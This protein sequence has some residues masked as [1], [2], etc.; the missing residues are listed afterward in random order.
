MPSLFVRRG[1][2]PG[3]EQ[4]GRGAEELVQGRKRRPGRAWWAEEEFIMP[5]SVINE[6]LSFCPQGTI[7]SGD[8]MALEDYKNDVQRLRG[9]QPGIARRELENMA[10]RQSSF[11]A[12]GLAQ[13]VAKRYAPGVRDDADLDALETA[14]TAAITA[15]IAASNAQTATRLATKRTIG[16]VAFDGSANIHHYATC[17]TAAATAAKTV[18]LSGFALATGARVLVKFTVTNSAA[19]PTLDVNGTGAKPIQYRGAAIAAGTLAANRTYEF[20]Y[21]GAQYELVG[22]VDTNTTYSLATASNDGLMAKGDK[23]KL[24]GI[25]V[26]A[27]VNQNA[28]GNILVGSTT[29]A[30]DT[31]T[32]TLTFVAGTNVTLT[33]DATNDKLTIAA[34]DTTYAAAT[35]SV[36]GLMSAADKKSVDYCEALR[37]SMIGVPRYWRSTTLPANH[38]WAN[39]DL[40]LFSDWP[41]LKKVYDG[42]GFTGMLLAYNAA[43]ATIAA[44]LGK[45]RPNA[46]NPTGL[47][48]PK[49]SDQFFRAWTGGGDGLAGIYN[50]PGLPEIGGH[51]A[52]RVLVQGGLTNAGVAL[53]HLSGVFHDGRPDTTETAP[54]LATEGTYQVPAWNIKMLASRYN[55][56]YS[57]SDTVMPESVNLPVCLYLGLHT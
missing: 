25:A 43:S 10:L 16:G 4:E 5:T 9:H 11:V 44:N 48:V 46:A 31:K 54:I 53:E 47:Y 41:E 15:L 14:I 29:I 27:E 6:I 51:F 49:L 38:V 56:I 13:F 32:D 28:F 33:P 57:A 36:A 18:A 52:P 2:K 45:W 17:S 12:A 24:D 55:P 8:I 40:V 7:A 19:N 22:D 3:E 21:T 50:A 34:K 37:L 35:Q 20:V 1:R 26:G 30:A 23:G 39:G 42:G